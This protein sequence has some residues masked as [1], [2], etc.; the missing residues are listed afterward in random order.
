MLAGFETITH[1]LTDYESG[2]LLPVFLR[3]LS[4]KRGKEK[5]ITNKKMIQFLKAKDYKISDARVRKIINHI[6]RNFLIP[7]L[8]ATSSG[9]F[10]SSDKNEIKRYISSLQGRENEIRLIKEGMQT[11]LNTL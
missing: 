1:D 7:G 11:Y 10:I 6:R 8:I 4:N 3:G 9:Y 5:A 2:T